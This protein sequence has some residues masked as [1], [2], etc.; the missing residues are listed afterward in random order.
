MTRILVADDEA[1]IL[2]GFTM[3]LAGEA[4][5]Y[6]VTCVGSGEEALA[7]LAAEPFDLVFTDLR[8]AGV[9]GL[10][11][12]RKGRALR[13]DAEFVL[14]TGYSS[15]ETAVDAMKYGA[16]DYLQKPFTTDEL[17]AHV[18][19]ADRTRAE[20]IRKTEE[21]RGFER[22]TKAM[23]FQHWGLIVTFTLLSLTGI[24]LLFPDTF[25]GVFFFEDSSLLRGMLHRIAAVAL[26]LMSAFHVGWAIVTDEG[27]RNLRAV[28][29]S[30]PGDV[31]EAIGDLLYQLG[32]RKE[33][34]KAGKY[35]WLEKF[36]YFA[37]VW[38][39]IVMVLSGFVLWFN[40]A[41]LR[42][43][44]LWV[45]DIAKV[46][47]RYEAILAI[48]SIAVWHMYTVHWRPGVFPMSR[49]FL[50]GRISRKDM[51]HEHPLEYEALTGRPAVDDAQGE[52]RG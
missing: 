7:R 25:K 47:H 24:P 50:D 41:I 15:V 35:T 14:M 23:R 46:V 16:L 20:R 18:A 51:M 48:V 52:V 37:V 1:S 8:M 12:V 39:T 13:P 31:K 3:A 10:E 44:P 19:R 6:A 28:L 38:G 32:L 30:L 22:F 27:H 11:V 40:D 5:R 17:V 2:Q 36:E 34:P 43:A 29:P 49:V 45:I 26:I 42:I 33:P 9:D 4:G 21:E